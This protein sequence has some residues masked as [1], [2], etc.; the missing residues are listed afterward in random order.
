MKSKQQG[1]AII[2]VVFVVALASILVINLTYSTFLSTR[3][4]GMVERQVQAEYLLKSLVNFSQVLLQYDDTPED[5]YQDLWG[6]FASN[7]RIPNE[8]LG[9]SDN[10]SEIYLEII[11]N[12]SRFN[13]STLASIRTDQVGQNNSQRKH[14][15]LA[16]LEILMGD[17]YLDFNGIRAE[18]ET[19]PAFK[20]RIFSIEEVIAN[21]ID[22]QDRD[23]DSFQGNYYIGI[24]GSVDKK[25]VY[26]NSFNYPGQIAMVPGITPGRLSA[27]APFIT[28]SVSNKSRFAFPRINIHTASDTILNC[29]DPNIDGQGIRDW[30]TGNGPFKSIEELQ[31]SQLIPDFDELRSYLDIKSDAFKVYAKVQ[32]GLQ[33]AYYAKAFILKGGSSRKLPNIESALYY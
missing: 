15:Y 5:S 8:Y 14:P 32:Y 10:S 33:R 29:L 9:L 16:A 25:D 18:E 27:L 17:Q 3:A 19:K 4:I 30:I 7:P 24:E 13:I 12:N 31:N 11:P 2:L 6:I 23:N 21:L 22:W 1:I 20:G 26:N 28:T